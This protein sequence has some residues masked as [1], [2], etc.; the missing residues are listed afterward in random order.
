MVFSNFPPFCPPFHWVLSLHFHGQM[1][2]VSATLLP[3]GA[4]CHCHGFGDISK[5][6]IYAISMTF[7]V[8]GIVLFL[9]VARSCPF[10]AFKWNSCVAAGLDI[11]IVIVTIM[12]SGERAWVHHNFPDR[13]IYIQTEFEARARV[14]VCLTLNAPCLLVAH[15]HSLTHSVTR[16]ASQMLSK[17]TE[18]VSTLEHMSNGAW[19]AKKLKLNELNAINSPCGEF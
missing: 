1:V 12:S 18:Y 19:L 7:R 15:T 13:S 10:G 5:G 11:V 14:C 6:Y 2:I 17:S 3:P 8:N 4:R 16:S 9:L